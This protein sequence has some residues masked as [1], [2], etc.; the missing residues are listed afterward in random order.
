M[1]QLLA[2]HKT[3]QALLDKMYPNR[4]DKLPT[5]EC[6]LCDNTFKGYGNSIYPFVTIRPDEVCCDDCNFLEVLPYRMTGKWSEKK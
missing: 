3:E 1:N 5:K 6:C 4:Y 2:K